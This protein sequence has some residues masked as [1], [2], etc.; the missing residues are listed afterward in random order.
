MEISFR[1]CMKKQKKVSRKI[2]SQG[3]NSERYKV[4]NVKREVGSCHCW[5]SLG[6][7]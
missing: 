5:T 2:E 7:L 3:R 6:L 4:V 1:H